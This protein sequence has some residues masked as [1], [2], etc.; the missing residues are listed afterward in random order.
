[1]DIVEGKIC[2][3]GRLAETPAEVG[4]HL[5]VD[6]V[7]VLQHPCDP[8][9]MD[10]GR[11]QLRQRGGNGLHQR[12]LTHEIYVSLDGKSRSR[13]GA[14]HGCYVVTVE[15]EPIR[16]DEP[17]LD[18][19]F[20]L[21]A[22]V[23]VENAVNPLAAQLAIG[24]AA[25]QGGILP[26]HRGLVAVP[27]ERPCLHL[28]LVE[29]ARVKQAVE[30]VLVVVALGADGADLPLELFGRHRAHHRRTSMPSWAISQPAASIQARSGEPRLRAGFEL[31]MCVKMRRP[32]LSLARAATEPSGP[33]ML[34]C[35]MRR[36]V[37]CDRPCTIISSSV[38]SVPSKRMAAAPD[39]RRRSGGS[40]AGQPGT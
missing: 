20:L 6:E 29:L 17:P 21:T 24:R 5:L 23:M 34:I 16:Q 7:V 25:H 38:K 36:P 39:M 31:L 3:A 18:P 10:R 26:R 40:T 13:Q 37:F 27:V 2:V 33:D 9:A 12:A 35:P 11:E 15:A 22:A 8:L 14:G 28:A 4:H 32:T 19:A 1:F 30:R